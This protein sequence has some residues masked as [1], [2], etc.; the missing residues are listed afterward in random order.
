VGVITQAFPYEPG[1]VRGFDGGDVAPSG[2]DGSSSGELEYISDR[3][4]VR[5]VQL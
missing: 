2:G 5:S 4:Q 3:G 1:F